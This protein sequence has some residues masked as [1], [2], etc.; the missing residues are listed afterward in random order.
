MT[1]KVCGIVGARGMVG[2]VLLERM[3]KKDD[4]SLIEPI[5]FSTSQIGKKFTT[6]T[7]IEYSF[8]DATDLKLL[9]SCEIII[10]TQGGAYTDQIFPK[11]RTLGWTGHWIDAASSLRMKDHSLIVLDP[12]NGEAIKKYLK[13]GGNNFIGAN[14]TVSLMLMAI[15]GLLK[16]NLVEW[17]SS[18]TYQAAS[19]AGA[20]QMK[21]LLLQINYLGK[22]LDVD[23]KDDSIHALELEKKCLELVNSTSFPKKSLGHKLALNLLPFIDCEWEEGQSREEWKGGAE[24]GKIL[25]G[26]N[27]IIVDGTCVRVGSLRCHSQA[28]TIKLRKDISLSEAESCLKNSPDWFKWVENNK[29]DSLKNLTPSSISGTLNI[30]VGRVRKMK[31]G[32]EF[33]NIFTVGDQLLWGAA[34]PLRRTLRFLCTGQFE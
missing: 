23:L 19:G 27:S 32:P 6:A 10:T 22:K 30:A 21:E 33:L 25:S 7:G 2:Q 29:E 14:C 1:K 24:A 9:K 28:L 5:F 20:A 11:L 18:M 12:L 16:E 34:E 17:V 4:F 13:E 8:H 15:N 3:E 26:K 31:M